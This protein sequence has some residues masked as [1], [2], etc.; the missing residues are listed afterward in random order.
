MLD[1]PGYRSR[2]SPLEWKSSRASRYSTMSL[3]TANDHH[4]DMSAIHMSEIFSISTS[5][6][7]ATKGENRPRTSGVD[8]Y[9]ALIDLVRALGSLVVFH[10][11]NECT[12]R[13]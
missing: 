12:P 9:Q 8:A 2:H 7:E 13:L 6:V 11:P 3:I 1:S 10:Q 4:M 5:S